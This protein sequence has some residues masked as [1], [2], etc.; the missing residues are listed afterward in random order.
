MDTKAYIIISFVFL[1]IALG[2]IGM[3]W[4]AENSHWD[5]AGGNWS[6]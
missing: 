3:E 6:R 4:S 2:Y 1:A 5:D